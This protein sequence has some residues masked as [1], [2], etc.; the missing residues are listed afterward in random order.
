MLWKLISE[1][2][3]VVKTVCIA[4]VIQYGKK[5]I[6]WQANRDT[7]V[8]VYYTYVHTYENRVYLYTYVYYLKNMKLSALVFRDTKLINRRI[9]IQVE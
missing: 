8:F 2:I 6:C 3:I 1:K 5:G 4:F 7:D 9:Q